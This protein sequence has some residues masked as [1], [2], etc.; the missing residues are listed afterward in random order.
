MPANLP[1]QYQKLE[2][3]YRLEK[4]QGR[5]LE[6]L[7]EMLREIPK[8]KGT[9]HLQGELKSK[10][11]KLKQQ[12]GGGG[13]TAVAKHSAPDHIPREGAGQFVLFGPPNSG[14]SSII[15]A[16]TKAHVEIT[17]WPFATR[18]PVPGM[19]KWENVSLQLIDTPS[20]AEEYCETYV[21]NIIRTCDIAVLVV[22]L[23]D[24]DIVERYDYVI[25]RVHEGKV[26]LEGL[27][28]VD[29]KYPTAML[30]KTLIVATGMDLPDAST[31]LEFLTDAVGTNAEII[32][33]S[34]PS[35]EGLDQFLARSFA[36]LELHRV[37]TKAPGKQPDL[38]DPVLLSHGATVA[39]AARSIHKDLGEKLQFARI[40]S[41]AKPTLDGTRVPTDH[42]VEDGDILEFHV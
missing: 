3:E 21:F 7:Q 24:D 15:G 23:G 8:H 25:N 10:I 16:L 27:V 35:R 9:N 30:K 11:S 37:Y 17:D 22:S 18:K 2:E 26:R 38:D 31:R 33:V 28:E 19:A 36:L 1:P 40:W 32:T 6:L 41:T 39:D 29:P 14:K 5:R 12:M 13:K 20:I 4:D 34:S 42:I